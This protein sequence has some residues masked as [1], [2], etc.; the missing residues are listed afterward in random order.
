MHRLALRVF[1]LAVVL[2]T[3]STP[4]SARQPTACVTPIEQHPWGQFKPGSWKR[5]RVTTELLNSEGKVE[6]ETITETQTTLEA[7]EDCQFALK[8]E[9]TVEIAG[10]RF[11]AQPQY[12]TQGINGEVEGQ[13]SSLKTL[14]AGEISIDGRTLPCQIK[15]VT[16]DGEGTR[17]VSTLHYCAEVPPYLLKRSTTA[18]DSSTRQ[19]KYRTDVETMAVA[20]PF[21]V[22]NQIMSTAW[23]RTVHRHEDGETITL[24]THC[25]A[26]PGGVVAHTSKELDR[27]GRLVRRSTLE[28]VDYHVAKTDPPEQESK[29]RFFFRRRD[30]R[31]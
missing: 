18:T 15:Q 5:V 19:V 30:R 11:V 7:V 28:L 20:M 17:R 1:A 13:T 4:A 10:K 24:E 22:R 25:Q 12:V 9:V 3:A 16:I 2:A 26:V 31:D 21:R 29:R 14:G 8:I 27:S 23:L 6:S